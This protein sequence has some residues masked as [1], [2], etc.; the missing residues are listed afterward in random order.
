M[1]ENIRE[2]FQIREIRETFLPRMIP[3]IRY[4]FLKSSLKR[5]FVRTLRTPPPYASEFE[6][7][8]SGCR[9]RSVY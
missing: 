3:I 1:Q 5:G 6:I 2:C 7:R 4:L 9:V 8:D